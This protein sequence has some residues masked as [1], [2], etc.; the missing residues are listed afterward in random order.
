MDVQKIKRIIKLKLQHKSQLCLRRH[1]KIRK[2]A[3]SLRPNTTSFEILFSLHLN[4]FDVFSFLY[5]HKSDELNT[6]LL[7]LSHIRIKQH[8]F[9][10]RIVL[11][12]LDIR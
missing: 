8:A 7:L 11:P 10:F 2:F 9:S 6:V 3:L 4:I 5:I 12:Y 1:S